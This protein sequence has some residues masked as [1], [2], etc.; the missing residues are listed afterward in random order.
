[1]PYLN[2]L[3][4]LEQQYFYIPRKII[5]EEYIEELSGN[6]YDYK[7]HCFHGEPKLIQVIGDR[8]LTAHTGEE[9]FFDTDWKRNDFMYHSY[10]Q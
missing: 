5:A 8:D 2:G 3:F 9:A 1:M 6:L 7:I 4:G 10:Q